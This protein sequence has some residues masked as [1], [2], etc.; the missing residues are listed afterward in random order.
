MISTQI[1]VRSNVQ[2]SWFDSK[3]DSICEKK[4]K[5]LN[6]LKKTKDPTIYEEIKK[7]RKTFKSTVE[8]KKRDNIINDDDPALTKKKFLSYYK[9]I[10]NSCRIPETMNYKG[11][12]RSDKT[13]V[14][15]LFNK[16]FSDKFSSP[17]SYDISINF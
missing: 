5:L 16:Y 3:L 17:S 8:R 11:R 13:D 1:T 2:P 15:N 10:S 6:K 4:V 9:A 7:I 12:Y 14:A